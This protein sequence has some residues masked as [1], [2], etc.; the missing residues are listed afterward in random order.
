VRR[1]RF[2]LRVTATS[3]GLA[4]DARPVGSPDQSLSLTSGRNMKDTRRLSPP[5]IAEYFKRF[6]ARFLKYESTDVADVE[7]VSPGGGDQ[8]ATTGAHLTGITYEPNTRSLEIELEAG[9][10]RAFRPKE[11]W[12]RED[13]DGF[14]RAIEV[15]LDDDDRE[16]IQIRRLGLAGASTK[17]AS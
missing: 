4:N 12:V 2:C 16:I 1:G 7:H 9:D 8:V 17:G 10:V 3:A 15:V 5:E 13:D 6:T 14:V 11:V